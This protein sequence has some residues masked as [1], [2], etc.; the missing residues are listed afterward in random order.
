[1]L[2]KTDK[3]AFTLGANRWIDY[4]YTADGTLLRKRQ[5]DNNTIVTTT[6]YIDGFV[7]TTTGAGTA[8]LAYFP[9]PEGRV[10]NTGTGG[11]VTLTQ[12]FVIG[13]QQGNARL[14]FQNNGSGKIVVKQENSYYP[15]GLIMPNS[16]V[17]T[18]TIPNKQLYNGGSEWQNDFADSPDYYQTFYR[19]YDAATM[20]FVAVDP[21]AESAH[22]MTTYQ[23]SNNNPITFN[24]P[25]GDLTAAQWQNVVN[26]YNNGPITEDRE[27]TDPGDNSD[28]SDGGGGGSG[29]G[30]SG[31]GATS[32][33]GAV[34]SD[35]RA[36]GNAVKAINN[37]NGWSYTTAG[38]VQTAYNNYIANMAASGVQS[39]MS[40]TNRGTILSYN[41][42]KVDAVGVGVTN[43]TVNVHLGNDDYQG[44]IG[45]VGPFTY[46]INKNVLGVDMEIYYK[47]TGKTFS[48]YNWV[49]TVVDTKLDGTK[50][51]SHPDGYNLPYYLTKYQVDYS[52]IIA[53]SRG[54]T[55]AMNDHPNNEL[56]FMA[57]TTVVGINE[58]GAV[59]P[60]ATIT[61]GYWLD[62]VGHVHLFKPK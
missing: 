28:A 41:Y 12:E 42:D 25:M 35:D 37:S 45:K 8:V 17:A 24:D 1:V 48:S 57:T 36:F 62:S 52:T 6:D 22:S 43:T 13:D 9:M 26:I 38:N 18:P 44:G 30:D 23:Y 59:T 54:Y 16:P 34:I 27:F 14:S 21:I 3:I 47:N 29:G 11:T 49:Q 56:Y 20:Q 39:T 31:G 40:L 2:N 50:L 58:Q 19:N 46:S 61:W 4:T 53:N 7:Y 55:I 5:Y 33:G 15:S 32:S 10:L 60:L 51:K